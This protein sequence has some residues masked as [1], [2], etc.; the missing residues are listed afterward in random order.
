MNAVQVQ[1]IN[2]YAL[3][4]VMYQFNQQHRDFHPNKSQ[5][6]I[7]IQDELDV[8][9][10]AAQSNWIADDNAWGLYIIN[11]APSYLGMLPGDRLT[12]IAKFVV[13][14]NLNAWHG[15]PADHVNK[16]HDIP[17]YNVLLS[18]LNIDLINL[19]KM[20]KI[21]RGQRCRI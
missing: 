17:D 8:F 19:P 6:K 11:D 1:Q 7:T 13:D 5:W 16:N 18:W 20:R 14:V 2:A 4:S 15:Y 9:S 3:G 12:F 10:H 21:I